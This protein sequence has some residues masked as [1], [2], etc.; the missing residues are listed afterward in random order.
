M[1][2]RFSQSSKFSAGFSAG[3]SLILTA[4][5]ENDFM[6][7]IWLAT[8]VRKLRQDTAPSLE[9]C[10]DA[11]L[12]SRFAA[13]R[14]EAAF[15]L[16]VYRHGAMIL[17]ACQRVLGHT[18]DAEDAFQATFLVLARKAASIRHGIT[19]PAWLH[20]VAVRIAQ[21]ASRKRS[22]M[23]VL[24]PELP[25]PPT[26]DAAEQR[27]LRGLLDSEID[28]LSEPCRRAF[29]LCYLEGLSN[30]DAARTLGC[31]VGTVES[32]LG[33]AR[34]R[35]RERLSWRVE[36]PTGILALLASRPELV[37]GT[38]T[39][40]TRASSL[41]A[42]RGLAAAIG[43]VREPV[44]RL[45]ERILSMTKMI[46]LSV[47]T[48]LGV[49]LIALA[50]GV[51][52]ANRPADPPAGKEAVASSPAVPQPSPQAAASLP[53]APQPSPAGKAP[54]QANAWP[55]AV[56]LGE[57]RS[58]GHLLGVA[59]NG[60]SLYFADRNWVT[61]FSYLK[62]RPEFTV[63]SKNTVSAAAISPDGKLV[64]TAEGVNGVKLRDSADGRVIEAFWPPDELPAEQIAFTPD[65]KTLVALCT[66]EESA[67]RFKSKEDALSFMPTKW[68]RISVWDV[69]TR[70]EIG[71]PT[72]KETNY[73]NT[74]PVFMLA[75][76]GRYVLKGQQLYEKNAEKVLSFKASRYT[77]FDPISGTTVRTIELTERSLG[78]M[79]P[80]PLSPDGKTLVVRDSNKKELRFLDIESG[81][82]RFHLPAFRRP[83]HVFAFSADGRFIATATGI[84]GEK[85]A[86]PSEVVIW[87]ASTGRELARMTD[88][89]S[90]RHYS[91]LAFNSD[92]SFL[93][94]QVNGSIIIWGHPPVPEPEPIHPPQAKGPNRPKAKETNEPKPK[95]MNENAAPARFQSL[96]RDLSAEGVTDA[97]RVESLFLAALGRLPTDVE[98]R[99][100]AAQIA[101]RDDKA[102]ALRD[103]LSTLIETA[104]FKTHAEELG[105]LAK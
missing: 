45:A 72:Q 69:A 8:L 52:W 27:E 61:I 6:P 87:D 86:A 11:D 4:T 105:R 76:H 100:L 57:D 21:R 23:T 56:D 37:A 67:G 16:L 35:L 89:E 54:E 38:V 63:I 3:R 40:I 60:K 24:D 44:V 64:A 12:L 78:L 84:E 99:T 74:L 20:R 94:V 62:N 65:G 68:T 43:I 96:F 81:K 19:I 50:A 32:R 58:F 91:A 85:I 92:G 51:G 103:L 101:K 39:T 30:A 88:K 59:A 53:V 102:A 70:K 34:R 7:G 14:D 73:Q 46:N 95:E 47:A 5:G 10:S 66:K 29:V 9:E 55:L 18:E 98:A 83:I 75:G 31:P 41:A 93:V 104:E 26:P 71:H 42:E 17:A 79:L 1:N 90:I 15:E 33:A 49:S 22:V 80:D 28:R 97:R 77:I 36:L 48:I 13:T 25:A 82:D 2:A